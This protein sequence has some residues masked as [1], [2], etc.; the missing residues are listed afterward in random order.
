MS[1]AVECQKRAEGSKPRALR[2]EGLIP[3]V[4]YGHEGTESISL[5]L[6]EKDAYNLLKKASINNTLVDLNIADIP[7]KGRALIREVQRHPW[8]NNLYHL[9]FFSVSAGESLE[10]VVPL[11]LVGEAKGVKLGGIL[12]QMLTELKIQCI[13]SQI[14]DSIDIDISEMEIGATLLVRELNLSEGVKALD[15]PER[16]VLSISA[17][18]KITEPAATEETTVEAEI[19]E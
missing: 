3:A 1:I 17:P 13:P 19:S 9:S 8:K 14:P 15:D 18:A 11:K 5:T 10:L 7:W 4:L 12:E 16:G 2:R 6:G